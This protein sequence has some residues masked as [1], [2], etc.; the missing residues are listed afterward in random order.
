MHIRLMRLAIAICMILVMALPSM[1]AKTDYPEVVFI[2][3]ASGSMWG[4]AGGVPKIDIAKKVMA[5]AVPGLPKEV[6]VGLVAYGHRRKGDCKDVEI[7]VKPGSQ[8]RDGLLAKVKKLSP[9]GKTPLAASVMQTAEML[10]SKENETTIILVSDG[11]ETCHDDPCNSI[12]KLKESGIKFILHV[13]GFD[14]DQKGKKQ[15]ECLAQAGAGEY[16][17]ASDAD[18]LLA[19]LNK[20]KVE[21]AQK[22]EKAKSKKVKAKSRLGKLKISMP[23]DSS[24]TLSGVRIVRA[25]DNKKIKETQKAEGTHPLLAGKY[26]VLLLYAN[27]NYKEADQVSI[28]EYEVV[29]GETTEINL[30]ALA[31]N[32]ADPLG[33]VVT[34]VELMD[35]DAEKRYLLHFDDK[36]GYYMFR[37]RPLPNGTYSLGFQLGRNEKPSTLYRDI[38]IEPG[39]TTVQTVDSGIQLKK[40]PSADVQAW[41]L[42][43]AG[44]DEELFTIA[45]RWDNDWPIWLAMPAPP[46][47]YDLWVKTKGMEDFLPVG[48]GI[49]INK[50]ETLS[51]DTGL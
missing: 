40:A 11:I 10:K 15:L 36:N 26:K 35:Q 22:V 30:G 7:L 39:K 51:F 1:A 50:G 5:K 29:G 12:K 43:K 9:K 24:K 47:T 23:K 21:V 25:K 38:K 16:F 34:G 37:N 28:G 44:S 2:L 31:I 27:T 8:D 33:K 6:R 32:I 17:T 41:K 48:E 3:D 4:R 42:T 49:E 18:S 45:R 13:V 14:V 19:A 46:G 20:V